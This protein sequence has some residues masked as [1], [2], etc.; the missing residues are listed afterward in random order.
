MASTFVFNVA[1]GESLAPRLVEVSG[2]GLAVLVPD[3]SA[4][5]RFPDT[6]RGFSRWLTGLDQSKEYVVVILRPSGVEKYDSVVTAIRDAGLALGSEL[7]GES[8]TVT[9]GSEE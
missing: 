6:G 9:L 5:L 8:V 3:R 7:A 2:E 4:P 1:A